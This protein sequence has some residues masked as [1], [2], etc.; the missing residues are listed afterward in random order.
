VPQVAPKWRG[1]EAEGAPEGGLALTTPAAR[2][3]YGSGLP[4][5]FFASAGLLLQRQARLTYR[6]RVFVMAKINRE[7][8]SL[9]KHRGRN[10][11]RRGGGAPAETQRAFA[12][13]TSLLL[14]AAECIVMGLIVGSLFYQP[15]LSAF[16]LRTSLAQY[17]ATFISFSNAAELPI[18]YQSKRVVA[19]HLDSSMYAPPAC[20]CAVGRQR[21]FGRS[22]NARLFAACGWR[23]TRSAPGV[24]SLYDPARRGSLCPADAP[25]PRAHGRLHLRNGPVST[26]VLASGSKSLPVLVKHRC[27]PN[28]RLVSGVPCLDCWRPPSYLRRRRRYWMSGYSPSNDGLRYAFWVTVRRLPR[29]GAATPQQR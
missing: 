20:E 11:R 16:T 17:A 14:L 13:A 24:Y 29:R 27:F 28:T 15:P 19:R 2:R 25:A 18:A 12:V 9:S 26:A 4:R 10:G 21:R 6:N 7:S 1:W 22:L 3:Q 5:S 8:S 23:L